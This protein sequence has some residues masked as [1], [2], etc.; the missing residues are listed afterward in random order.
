MQIRLHEMRV[1]N[2]HGEST[3]PMPGLTDDDIRFP[4]TEIG[5][6]PHPSDAYSENSLSRMS[7]EKLEKLFGRSRA[8]LKYR[9]ETMKTSYR[10]AVLR[11]TP[12]Y[13]HHYRA[14]SRHY[15]VNYDHLMN[16]KR[17]NPHLSMNAIIAR[18]KKRA[19]HE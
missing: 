19:L 2:F 16:L 13:T 8:T 15:G 5:W 11:D 17:Q 18:L 7:Y 6:Q 4:G 3:R 10:D 14:M 9:V 12:S 1:I